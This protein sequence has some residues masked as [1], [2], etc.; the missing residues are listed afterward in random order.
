MSKFQPIADSQKEFTV[1]DAYQSAVEAVCR[2]F[3]NSDWLT[4]EEKF[5]YVKMSGINYKVDGAGNPYFT[6]KDEISKADHYAELAKVLFTEP[7]TGDIKR[8]V[9]FDATNFFFGSFGEITHTAQMYLNGL[10]NA[11]FHLQAIRTANGFQPG[12]KDTSENTE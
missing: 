10:E 3:I 2:V 8:N 5:H 12:E 6:A 9:I 4:P 7:A 11:R 1:R